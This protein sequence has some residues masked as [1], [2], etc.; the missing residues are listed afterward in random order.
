MCSMQSQRSLPVLLA[1][2]L[3]LPEPIDHEIGQALP[4]VPEGGSPRAQLHARSFRKV[5]KAAVTPYQALPIQGPLVSITHHLTPALP[6]VEP[7]SDSQQVCPLLRTVFAQKYVSA[8]H[9]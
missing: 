2:E 4:S 1:S 9:H 6:V 5:Q 7:G 8:T 3:S